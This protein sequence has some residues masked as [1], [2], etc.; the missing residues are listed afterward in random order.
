MPRAILELLVEAIDK[1]SGVLDKVEQKG[2]AL[3]KAWDGASKLV[4]AGSLAGGAG[5]AGFAAIAV[6][7]AA[8]DEAA[9]NRM[10][11]SLENLAVAVGDQSTATW[12]RWV[13]GVDEAIAA[14]ERKAFSDDEIRNGL[15]TL[16]AATGD[17]DQ[18]QQRL[19]AAQ[20]LARGKNISLEQASN[21]LARANEENVNVLRRMGIV[22]A[23][24]ATEADLLAAVQT[25]FAGQ[26]DAY[27]ASTAGQF[28]QAKIKIG[29][30]TE[31][32]GTLLLP[33]V[34][35]LATEGVKLLDRFS[36]WF[37]RNRPQIEAA[38]SSVGTAFTTMTTYFMQGLEL[39]WPLIQSVFNFLIDNQP[40]LI[41]VL[42]AIGV[43]VT[44]A[45]GPVGVAFV[46]F[47]GFMV[48][49]GYLRDHWRDVLSAV[50]GFVEQ[51]AGKI[52]AIF[53]PAGTLLV[54]F[55]RF[56]DTIGTVFDWIQR[57]IGLAADAFDGVSR[58]IS[59]AMSTIASAVE[60]AYNRIKPLIDFIRGGLGVV[61]S[62]VPNFLGGVPGF[63][64]G[65]GYAP[66]GLSLV[67]EGGPELVDL[68][69]GSR[70]YPASRTA[71][72]LGGGGTSVVIN[73]TQPLGTPEAIADAVLAALDY[74]D[75]RGRAAL[76]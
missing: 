35:K 10:M 43:A 70:V 72:M 75:R 28:E 11:L 13:A 2:H 58:R 74:N 34:T 12:D 37:E 63:A 18:A 69:R 64:S 53:G 71:G 73:I 36:G 56:R 24:N 44:A 7:A 48:L 8:E 32:A 38:L 14:G 25:K 27:G 5:L 30:L 17:Y 40:V 19:S 49:L 76:A 20:D 42:V 47:T 26:A 66:G 16:I 60:S 21:L 45:F 57:A 9:N 55:V 65:T 50:I 3:G 41:A 62:A 39:V 46:A 15:Q 59:N 33:M 67:G 31:A 23:E 22:L 54:L 29:E 1:A 6:K 52:T 61:G 4:V 51:H 68:P